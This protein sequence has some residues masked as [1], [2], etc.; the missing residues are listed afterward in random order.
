MPGRKVQGVATAS[1]TPKRKKK[2]CHGAE[3][4]DCVAAAAYIAVAAVVT[5]AADVAAVIWP[6][7]RKHIGMPEQGR[8]SELF[9]MLLHGRRDMGV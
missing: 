1:G 3:E 4:A 8:Q 5:A 9:H 2:N 7:Q 6:C